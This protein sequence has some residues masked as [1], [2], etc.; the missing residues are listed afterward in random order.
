MA[1][2]RLHENGQRQDIAAAERRNVELPG[3]AGMA[4]VSHYL[5]TD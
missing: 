3:N 4:V 1:G 2:Q 5:L